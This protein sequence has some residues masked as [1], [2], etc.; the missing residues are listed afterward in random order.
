[1]QIQ[2]TEICVPSAVADGHERHDNNGQTEIQHE[3]P[4]TEKDIP[5]TEWTGGNTESS[6]DDDNVGF[7]AVRINYTYEANSFVAV[8]PCDTDDGRNGPFWIGKVLSSKTNKY[9]VVIALRVHWFGTTYNGSST[10][11]CDYFRDAFLSL[12]HI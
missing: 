8:Q 7:F 1:M 9:G 4:V 11:Q 6:R 3:T 12:I 2:S 10:S 5:S